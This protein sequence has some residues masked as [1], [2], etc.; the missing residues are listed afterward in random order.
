[1]KKH[2]N[3]TYCRQ[4]NKGNPEALKTGILLAN[5]KYIT[6]LDS[7]DQYMKNHLESRIYFFKNNPKIDL[8]YSTATIIGSEKDFFVPDARNKKRLIHLDK[9]IIGATFF[10]KREVFINL[11]GFK[12]KYSH[13]FD[14]YKRAIK[15]YNVF[16]LEIPTYI[17]FRGYHNGVINN[18]KKNM[19]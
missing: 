8:I 18:L 14:F 7:D 4:Q 12:N 2:N 6:F 9:C 17:Y 19:L 15:S 16:K 3:I 10:G 1:L 11:R 13:D 5:G